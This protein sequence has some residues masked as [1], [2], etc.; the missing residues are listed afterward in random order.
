MRTWV[1][2]FD[3]VDRQTRPR[4][5]DFTPCRGYLVALVS[6]DDHPVRNGVRDLV[7]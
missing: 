4:D 1:N 3:V 6:G 5:P 7:T 2:R